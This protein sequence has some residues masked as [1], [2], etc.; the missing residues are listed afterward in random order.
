MVPSMKGNIAMESGKD[1]EYT[2]GQMDKNTTV[3]LKIANGMGLEFSHGQMEENTTVL[4]KIT[5][6]MGLVSG[7][8]MV[9]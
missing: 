5:K 9:R 6:G 1:M 2:L 7:T 8:K 4:G 3:P